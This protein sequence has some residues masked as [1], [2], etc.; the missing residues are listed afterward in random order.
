[1]N[2][3]SPDLK[4]TILIKLV[5]TEG[6]VYSFTTAQKYIFHLPKITSGAR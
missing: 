6:S 2:G 5:T 4:E 1:M 3:P